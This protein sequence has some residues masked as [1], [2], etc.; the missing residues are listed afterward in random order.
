MKVFIRLFFVLTLFFCV[1]E[2]VFS[3]ASGMIG[4]SG[5]YGQTAYSMKDYDPVGFMPLG[6]RAAVGAYGIQFGPEFWTTPMGP[7]FNFTDSAT[8]TSLYSVKIHD[9]YFGGMIRAHAGDDPRDFAIVFRAGI[10]VF[11]S[12]KDIDYSSEYLLLNPTLSS[13]TEKFKNSIGYNGALGFSIP[14]GDSNVHLTLEG[15]FIYNPRNY[16]SSS[17]YHTTWNIQ[18]GVSYNLFNGY[19]LGHY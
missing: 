5:G 12:K 14:L 9:N 13:G 11:F 3:Q 15:Q 17:N 7:N 2:N 18:L 8:G 6:I 4:I 19:N 1:S 16:D 10:G